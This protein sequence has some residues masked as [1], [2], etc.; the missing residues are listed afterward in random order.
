MCIVGYLLIIGLKN[1]K[2]MEMA[3]IL[4]F[5]V[6]TRHSGHVNRFIDLHSDQPLSEKGLP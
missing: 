4:A 6:G 1:D 3:L 5:F 2:A